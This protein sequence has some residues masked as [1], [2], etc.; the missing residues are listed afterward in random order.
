[1]ELLIKWAFK[2]R[3][4]YILLKDIKMKKLFIFFALALVLILAISPSSSASGLKGK[5]AVGGMGSLGLPI[6]DFADEDKGAAKSGYGFLGLIEYYC[7]DNFA[8]GGSF[9]YPVFGTKTEDFEDMM[10]YLLYAEYGQWFNV[11]ADLKQKIFSFAVFGKYLFLPYS[12]ACP[13]LKFG[14]G[15]GKYSL[16]GDINVDAVSMDV[17]ASFDSKSYVNLGPGIQ[18]KVSENAALIFEATYTHVFTDE[19]EGE[20]EIKAGTYTAE[21]EVEL[22]FSAQYLGIYAGLCF[23]FG[24]KR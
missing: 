21:E 16:T 15:V 3:V 24:G 2:K 11:D 14:V 10:E 17:D 12:Q 7:S 23:F 20:L 13:Y 19:A 22:N 9:S 1:M 8:I 6:G 5:F 18:Y 4:T